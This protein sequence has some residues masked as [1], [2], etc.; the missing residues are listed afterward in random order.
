MADYNPTTMA[1]LIKKGARLGLGAAIDKQLARFSVATS[2]NG[3]NLTTEL[4]AADP[5]LLNYL[6]GKLADAIYNVP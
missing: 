4:A 1:A 6:A 5:A 3:P 2:H